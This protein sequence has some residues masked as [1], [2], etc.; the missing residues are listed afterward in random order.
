[1]NKTKRYRVIVELEDHLENILREIAHQRYLS[2]SALIRSLIVEEA[3]R[4][5]LWP[6]TGE[7]FNDKES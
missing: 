6:A 5:N 7:K 1:M 4:R 2:M 3:E